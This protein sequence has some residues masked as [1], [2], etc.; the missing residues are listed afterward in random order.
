MIDADGVTYP[1]RARL[2]VRKFGAGG[3][4]EARPVA[5]EWHY[6]R[7]EP[8][9]ITMQLTGTAYVYRFARELLDRGRIE[10]AGTVGQVFVQPLLS[11]WVEV[12]VRCTC[13]TGTCTSVALFSFDHSEIDNVLDVTE[14]L[15]PLGAEADQVDEAAVDAELARIAYGVA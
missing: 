8:W 3:P 14:Q 6:D 10:P 9:A 2:V 13:G 7:A 11:Q 12:T 4:A 1:T 15:V 5:I